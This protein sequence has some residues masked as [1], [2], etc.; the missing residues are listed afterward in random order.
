MSVDPAYRGGMGAQ[1]SVVYALR[2]WDSLTPHERIA[3]LLVCQQVYFSSGNYA[4][5]IREG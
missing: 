5:T 1:G 4:R 3:D 2:F